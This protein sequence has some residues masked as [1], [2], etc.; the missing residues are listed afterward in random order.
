VKKNKEIKSERSV[1]SFV[2]RL[3]FL[4]CK[5]WDPPEKTYTHINENKLEFK[6]FCIIGKNHFT[7]KL[8]PQKAGN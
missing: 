5:V 8:K 3:F 6:K 7:P 2:S 4:K 1:P